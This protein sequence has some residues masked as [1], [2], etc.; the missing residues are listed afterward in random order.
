MAPGANVKKYCNNLPQYLHF[1]G[2]KF[3]SALPQYLSLPTQ[4]NAIKLFTV[5]IYHLS[6]LI[7]KVM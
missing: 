7:A 3:Y 1:Q 4:A 2:L 6:T 5:V